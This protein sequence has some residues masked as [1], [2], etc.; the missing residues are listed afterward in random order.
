MLL[1]TL[2]LPCMFLVPTRAYRGFAPVMTR[3]DFLSASRAEELVRLAGGTARV[4]RLLGLEEALVVRWHFDGI[5]EA[6][7]AV[8]LENLAHETDRSRGRPRR[9]TLMEPGDL[10]AL[11][12]RAGGVPAVS[13]RLALHP[14]TLRRYVRGD[15]VP[16]TD[17]VARLRDLLAGS[18]TAIRGER[19][20]TSTQT[21]RPRRVDRRI[22]PASI[23][24]ASLTLPLL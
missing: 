7:W 23:V 22:V 18:G 24:P 4:A 20:G 9:S 17:V 21:V 6:L 16:P 5:S 12:E 14:R 1:A 11:V 19:R 15:T 13:L 2:L 10:K 3:L 8:G